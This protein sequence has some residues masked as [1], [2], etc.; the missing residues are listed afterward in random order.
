MAKPGIFP[1][2]LL[3]A[4]NVY[5]IDIYN[6][7]IIFISQLMHLVFQMRKF[8]L[9]AIL[10]IICVSA[11]HGSRKAD[12]SRV[13]ASI[14]VKAHY[15]F[16]IIHSRHLRPISDSYPFGIEANIMWHYNRER[17]YNKCLCF[18][19]IGLSLSYWNFDNP[20]VLG[21][22]LNMLF[23]LE[24]FFGINR[25]L[26]F[27]FRAGMGLSYGSKPYHSENNPDNMSY[28]TYISFPL[29]IA[30]TL[31]YKINSRWLLNLS[32]NYNH[33]S[34]GGIKEPNKGINY[35][36]V[37]AGVDYY[38]RDGSFTPYKA[39]D[40]KQKTKKR[41]LYY[42]ELFLTTQRYDSPGVDK[43]YPILGLTFR[44]SRQVSR[45]N[46]I[47][48]GTEAHNDWRYKK[49]M[50]IEKKNTDHRLIGVMAGNEFLLGQFVFYQ[51]FGIYVYNPYK[52]ENFYQRYGFLFRFNDFIIGGIGLKAHGH[53][54]DFLDVRL[55]VVL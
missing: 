2:N 41:N 21:H 12:S 4:P 5:S 35:P 3:H 15:G 42:F 39:T 45:I 53:V 10:F 9:T 19:R 55:G 27:S 47:S 18:P 13:P 8:I 44:Y 31:N 7:L 36:T 54:A 40:W 29:A 14:G 30:A 50:K 16:V 43:K 1:S 24:P 25:K 26:S 6:F 51:L 33:I 17:S 11:C 22:G 48:F 37:S 49:K 46:A 28:S 23:L 34:N 38:F 32:A 52:K 20:R